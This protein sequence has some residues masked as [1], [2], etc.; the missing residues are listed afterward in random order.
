MCENNTFIQ[1]LCG[2]VLVLL[3]SGGTSVCEIKP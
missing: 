2:T 1:S 3:D